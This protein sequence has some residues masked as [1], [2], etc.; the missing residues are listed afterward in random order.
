MRICVL[1]SGSGGNSTFV[2]S[3]STRFLVDAG[4]TAKTIVERLSRI[5]VDPSTLEGI[6][7]SHEYHDHIHGAGVLARKFKI[8]LYISQRALDFSSSAL[9]HLIHRHIAAD[10]P[11]Q[12]GS[13][14]ITPFSTPHD[15][16]DPL[17]FSLRT[18]GVRA[19]IVSDIGHLSESVRLRLKNA[20]ALVIE[21]NHDTEMLR[22]GTYPWPLKQ[23]VM[24]HVGHLSNEA[25]A[26][27]LSESFDGTARKVM[28][29]HLSRQNNHPQLAYISA[30]RALERFAKN[31]QLH[32]SLQDEISDIL[33][34]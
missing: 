29:I 5:D 28:L 21:S 7:I 6:F 16:V 30:C 1:G 17:A 18:G 26:S 33:E 13:V 14:T 31:T 20:D 27:F 8:P 25:L 10:V 4:L 11:I 32:I 15:S 23:R 2:E 34:V 12:L 19:C 3:G 9:H 24:S 22:T